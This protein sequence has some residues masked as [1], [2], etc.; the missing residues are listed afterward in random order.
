VTLAGVSAL[1]LAAGS[2]AEL[3]LT[4]IAETGVEGEF[5]PGL[6]AGT[7][8]SHVGIPVVDAAGN[9]VFYADLSG[10]SVSG[11]NDSAIVAG[12]P[13]GAGVVIREGDPSP[14]DGLPLLQLAPNPNAGHA[15]VLATDL[16]DYLVSSNG[17][18]DELLR[19]GAQAAEA[20]AG[21]LYNSVARTLASDIGLY[22]F[23]ASLTG[24]VTQANNMGVFAGAP[25]A[26]E[27]AVRKGDV[28]PDTG[29]DTFGG[30]SSL[31]IAPDGIIAL[32]ALLAD[33]GEGTWYGDTSG[34]S[35]V[36]RDGSAAPGMPAGTIF[37]AFDQAPSIASNGVIA[38][39][40]F[41]VGP[42]TGGEN[43]G[44][45][46][47]PP[48]GLALTLREGTAAPGLPA[49]VLVGSHF[50]DD[51]TPQINDAGMFVYRSR[52]I[53][54]GVTP[55]NDRAIFAGA[56]ASPMLIAREGDVAPD[57]GGAT[58]ATILEPALN[59]AGDIAFLT[60]IEGSGV[61]GDTDFAL[62][63]WNDTAGLRLVARDTNMVVFGV[64][65]SRTIVDIDFVGGVRG[66]SGL[67]TGIGDNGVIAFR[68][69]VLPLG[70]AIITARAPG[71]D[72]AD[73]NGD[74]AVDGMDLAYFL[75]SWGPCAGACPADFNGDNKVD[76]MD[77][78][79][80]LA[81]WTN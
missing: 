17:G 11:D 3:P 37:V 6:E 77:L 68:A 19:I 54:V 24:V 67:A 64:G 2:R 20:P 56:P 55:D 73:F 7:V 70:D 21:V 57:T 16:L 63:V 29:G 65:D 62:Y 78:A 74:G 61:S 48:G 40:G 42:V 15:D 75:A 12:P 26:L 52:L 28:A 49:G 43:E 13:T 39:K 38:F 5:G 34:L 18:L 30:L 76:G 9:V 80:L 47:G 22:A 14:L 35:L 79:L 1:A 66:S 36:V 23:I 41:T 72:P 10:P 81:S 51:N 58:F 71:S 44:L 53:G 69:S 27:M 50:V 4:R 60:R 45:W 8:Y 59:Q 31:G 33:G 25:D 46:I 32:H